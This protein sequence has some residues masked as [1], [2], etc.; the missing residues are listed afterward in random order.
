MHAKHV[1]VD[2]TP[3]FNEGEKNK[4]RGGATLTDADDV[5]VGH[6]FVERRGSILLD[7]RQRLPR[8]LAVRQAGHGGGGG[9]RPWRPRVCHPALALA[10][11]LAV[12]HLRRRGEETAIY[13]FTYGM[14]RRCMLIGQTEDGALVN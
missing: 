11:A 8:R 7:P 3:T 12:L 2:A 10:L 1:I 5:L 6:E 9:C 14:Y 13:V 4:K